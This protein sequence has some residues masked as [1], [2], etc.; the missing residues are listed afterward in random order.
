M[1]A[2]RG[3]RAKARCRYVSRA[4]HQAQ[5]MPQ[6]FLEDVS[7][8]E[9]CGGTDFLAGPLAGASVGKPPAE[10]CA[11]DFLDDVSEGS[12]PCPCEALVP[13]PPA[14]AAV[15]RPR[16]CRL[17]GRFGRGRHGDFAERRALMAHARVKRAER[18]VSFVKK[19]LAQ[20][21]AK[22]LNSVG[23]RGRGIVAIASRTK[24]SRELGVKI[25]WQDKSQSRGISCDEMLQEA[26]VGAARPGHH[27]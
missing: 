25:Q 8:E 9:P 23:R 17:P 5:R 6:D 18:K 19:V 13:A 15:H 14:A 26:R 10:P 21:C 4:H 7:D 20:Q 12:E 16:A 11:P 24:Y 27:A 1:G 22:Y 2:K 3:Q